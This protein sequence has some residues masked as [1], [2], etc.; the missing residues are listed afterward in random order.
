MPKGASANLDVL[1]S[2]AVLLVLAQHLSRRMHI[3]HLAW[4]P[5]SSLGFFGVLLFFVHTSL[6][7]MYSMDRSMHRSGLRGA[8]LLRDFYIRRAFRIYP[9]SIVAICAALALHL[10]SDV[11]GV[12]GLSYAQL[13]GKLAILSQLLLV[14]NLLHVKSIVNVLWSLPYEVQMYLFLPFLFAWVQRKRVF[15]SLLALWTISLVA[16]WAQMNVAPLG[17]LSLLR[18]VPCFLPGVIAYASPATPR[19][20][21][22]VW[23]IF[24][25][26][27]IGAFAQNPTLQMGWVLCL[28]LGLLIPFFREIQ[29]GPIRLISNR[30]AT[31]SYGIYISHQFCIWFALGI[32]AARPIWLRV[33]VLCL[34]LALVPILLYHAI[35]KPMIL[36]GIRLVTRLREKETVPVAVAA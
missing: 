9:L 35:E 12:A 18:F 33:G 36:L 27:L 20:R 10:G 31:Y 5:T 15:W 2:V 3:E 25:L 7:L 17:V 6:V 14:Q 21:A 4:V 23:P 34:S 13:P 8:P 29:S 30:I 28:L 24:I 26:G 11:N 22:Y 32:L 1:R 19:L 16:A